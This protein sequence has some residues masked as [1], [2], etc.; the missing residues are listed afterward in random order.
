[1]DLKDIER[2]VGQYVGWILGAERIPWFCCFGTLLGFIRD[3]GAVKGD[4]DIDL[5]M[6]YEHMDEERIVK[7]MKK[8][9]YTLH[10]KI[11]NNYE[12]P[13]KP[14]YLS[15]TSEQHPPLCLFAW[16]KHGEFRYHTYD[17]KHEKPQG[18]VPSE[19]V[20]KGVPANLFDDILSHWPADKD[21][22]QLTR[23]EFKIPRKY[24][25]L[26][27]LW[28]PDWKTPRKGESHT[29]YVVR[30][31]NCKDWKNAELIEKCHKQSQEEYD[32]YLDTLV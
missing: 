19:Y 9:N 27:D 17:T 5:G 10:H 23:H 13:N 14:Y 3:N 11:V 22:K 31:K 28:Y 16:V 8:Y 29:P 26:L 4:N 6:F 18:G 1:M 20:F 25:T 12:K 30:M 24:G 2:I 32:S 21:K 7:G 15:F